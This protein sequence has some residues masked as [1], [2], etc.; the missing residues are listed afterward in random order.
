MPF[1]IRHSGF[2]YTDEYFAPI[3]ISAWIDREVFAT[4]AAAVAAVRELHRARLAAEPLSWYIFNEPKIVR[5]LGEYL[6]EE[7]PDVVGDELDAH[8]GWLDDLQLPEL[9]DAQI[10]KV[11][12]I[13]ELVFAQVFEVDVD[14]LDE[15]EADEG[16][17]AGL[18]DLFFGS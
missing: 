4:E 18:D 9:T 2:F 7:L 16:V 5:E 13:T 14:E 15:L 10:D 8:G 11:L 17:D 12:E 6:Q 1:I 3:E